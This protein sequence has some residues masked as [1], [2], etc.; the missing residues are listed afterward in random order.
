LSKANVALYF[1]NQK[2]LIPLDYSEIMISRTIFRDG[3]S[4]YLINKN[5]TK[6]MDVVEILAK[7]NIGCRGFSV[8]N[9][10]MESEIL[11][12]SPKELYELLEEASGVRYL[13]LKKKRAESRLKSTQ[14]NIEKAFSVLKEI[15]PHLKYLKKETTKI[16]RKE[17][18]KQKL[19]KTRKHFFLLSIDKTEK[20]KSEFTNQKRKLEV[21]VLKLKQ[22]INQL[23]QEF[24]KEEANI[25]VAEN[26]FLKA[27]KN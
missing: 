20:Q 26:N 21:K 4:E 12:Y 8:I 6:L 5:P 11:K 24:K 9:Q 27:K 16:Q 3:T 23:E 25:I 18:L 1:D 14:N 7:A 10:G 15:V 2:G 17:K 22:E 13:Q 19:T